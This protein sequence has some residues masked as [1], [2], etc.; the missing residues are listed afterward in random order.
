MKYRIKD[1]ARVYNNGVN[2]EGYIIDETALEN[3]MYN[4][5]FIKAQKLGY[6]NVTQAIHDAKF[7]KYKKK[8]NGKKC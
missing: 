1:G 3:D 6:A 2:K 5:L 8:L 4:L 7:V